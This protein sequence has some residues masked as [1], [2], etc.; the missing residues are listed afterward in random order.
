MKCRQCGKE[1]AS[2]QRRAYCSDECRNAHYGKHQERRCLV[3]GADLTGKQ[4]KYCS[5]KCANRAKTLGVARDKHRKKRRTL[6]INGTEEKQYRTEAIIAAK[7]LGYGKNIIAQLKK[8]KGEVEI[9]RIMTQARK[10]SLDL[11]V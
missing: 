5:D 2:T 1:L 4:R 10:D 6:I 9:A 7:D 8:A 11:V 3:C